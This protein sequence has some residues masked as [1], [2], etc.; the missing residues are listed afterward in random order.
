MVGGQGQGIWE[1]AS[2]SRDSPRERGPPGHQSPAAGVSDEDAEK[3]HGKVEM[4]GRMKGGRGRGWGQVAWLPALAMIWALH[5]PRG[6]L[7]PF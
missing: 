5:L 6:P 3:V 7:G 2:G 1:R 4:T